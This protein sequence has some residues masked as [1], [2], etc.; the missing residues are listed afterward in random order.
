M[1]TRQLLR[2]VSY[3]LSVIRLPY[4]AVVRPM[5]KDVDEGHRWHATQLAAM[6]DLTPQLGSNRP[7]LRWSPGHFQPKLNDGIVP[8]HD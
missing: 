1:S 5:V 7:L 8:N 2:H 4:T 3:D 6:L